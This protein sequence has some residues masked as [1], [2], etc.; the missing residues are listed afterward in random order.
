MIN[1]NLLLLGKQGERVSLRQR[2]L[3]EKQQFSGVKVEAD[4]VKNTELEDTIIINVE[5]EDNS[6][7]PAISAKKKTQKKK[8]SEGKDK[9]PKKVQILSAAVVRGRRSNKGFLKNIVDIMNS[10]ILRLSH[11]LNYII[12]IDILTVAERKFTTIS[13][14]PAAV[15]TNIKPASSIKVPPP[16]ASDNNDNSSS[17]RGGRRRN[18]K[19]D[20]PNDSEG[21][22]DG[23]M[24]CDDD[25]GRNDS[26]AT[27]YRDFDFAEET[28][29]SFLSPTFRIPQGCSSSQ[30]GTSSTETRN[31]RKY[32]KEGIAFEDLPTTASSASTGVTTSITDRHIDE[33]QSLDEMKSDLAALRN[34]LNQLSESNKDLERKLAE[35]H[36]DH[37]SMRHPHDDSIQQNH[38]SRRPIA[39]NSHNS[40]ADDQRCYRRGED[41]STDNRNNSYN[42]NNEEVMHHEETNKYISSSHRPEHHYFSDDHSTDDAYIRRGHDR[43][44]RRSN[45][46]NASRRRWPYTLFVN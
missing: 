27:F 7:P 29:T 17:S 36:M 2:H 37:S 5:E 43:R 46:L 22:S 11:T 14:P 28:G 23:R 9:P 38:N 20:R 25:I 30:R 35:A 41:F 8:Q 34:S 12:I 24:Q 39:R 45:F 31:G 6:K 42:R 32:A 10:I 40:G 13:A 16:K 18:R 15:N 44:E 19:I 3:S 4:H 26:G 33:N 21:S 1:F